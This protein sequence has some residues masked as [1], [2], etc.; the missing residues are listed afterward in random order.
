M[1]MNVWNRLSSVYM[2]VIAVF[3]DDDD[4]DDSEYFLMLIMM[5]FDI[6]GLCCC[7]LDVLA[8]KV[9]EDKFNNEHIL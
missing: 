6:T 5:K 2:C 9:V 1:L 7:C 3:Y 4:G 8:G